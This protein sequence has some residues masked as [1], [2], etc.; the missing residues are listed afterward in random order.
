MLTE[1]DIAAVDGDNRTI[2]E[3]RI[4]MLQIWKGRFG[5][6]ATYRVFIEALLSCGRV[7]DAIEAC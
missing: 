5:F 1:A 7:S 3:K 4:G 6:K 2:A